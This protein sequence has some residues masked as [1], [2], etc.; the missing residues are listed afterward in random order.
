M[1]AKTVVV[2]TITHYDTLR[3]ERLQNSTQGDIVA[4]KQDDVAD[5]NINLSYEIREALKSIGDPS[6]V[7]TAEVADFLQ[8]KFPDSSFVATKVTDKAFASYVSMGRKKATEEKSSPSPITK[9]TT[10]IQKDATVLTSQN[11][12]T[13][14]CEEGLDLEVAV[15]GIV[16]ILDFVESQQKRHTL[17]SVVQAIL[18]AREEHE[19]LKKLF[20]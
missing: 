11:P 12:L 7:K 2:A 14:L 16:A 3:V 5:K 19:Q 9:S 13:R 15:S 10:I 1:V 6:T 18:K 17:E 20:G 4:K 8:R